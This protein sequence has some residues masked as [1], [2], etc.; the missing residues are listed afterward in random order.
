MTECL[1]L[2]KHL[3]ETHWFKKSRIVLLLTKV[4]QL[5][6]ILSYQPIQDCWPDYRGDPK[7]ETDVIRYFTA[8]FLSM[9]ADRERLISVKCVNLIDE[10]AVHRLLEDEIFILEEELPSW[11]LLK[12]R[13]ENQK[14]HH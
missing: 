2:F 8:R 12:I 3:L 6:S 7:S 5:Q 14:S 4:D 9:N 13:R 11:K 10:E 1:R